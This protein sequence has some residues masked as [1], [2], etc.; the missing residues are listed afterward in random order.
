MPKIVKE[1]VDNSTY[2][3]YSCLQNRTGEFS[4][5]TS[6]RDAAHS[7][8]SRF[9]PN[10]SYFNNHSEKNLQQQQP[11]SISRSRVNLKTAFKSLNNSRVRQQ[12]E[13]EHILK[14]EIKRYESVRN[15]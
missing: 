2:N 7:T 1:N 13:L 10:R 15:V 9:E 6:S 12:Y 5:D 3:N 8:I 4:N 11:R 14:N